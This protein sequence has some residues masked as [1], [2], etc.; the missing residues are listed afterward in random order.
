MPAKADL[1]IH[2]TASDGKAS[3]EEVVGG[4]QSSGL[5]V[6][7]ITDHDTITGVRAAQ[8]EAGQ[9]HIEVL[10]GVEITSSFGN[11]DCHLLAYH[12]DLTDRCLNRLLRHHQKVR[13]QRAICIIDQLRKE[14]FQIDLDEILAETPGNSVGR[15]HIAA[16]L[17]KKGCVASMKEAF[18]RYL[19]DKKLD[20]ISSE[21]HKS[22]E[23]IET[24]HQAGGAAVLAHPGCLYN[25]EEMNQFIRQGIDGIEVAHPSHR[26]K[27]KTELK[28]LADKHQLLITGGSDFH[29]EAEDASSHL[30]TA[31]VDIARVKEIKV[32]C[33]NDQELT[34]K[35]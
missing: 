6:I 27:M 12:F 13:R 16:V 20:G 2:T 7:S 24:V 1:H 4:A 21:F 17:Q 26:P 10:T 25:T 18:I 14:G 30:G 19:S 22:S 33:G 28:N 8:K 9:H 23:V 29:G 3:P 32:F 35:V 15:P 5:S 34:P 31:A 11:R